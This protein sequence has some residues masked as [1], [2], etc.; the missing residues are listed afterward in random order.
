MNLY[1]PVQCGTHRTPFEP[2]PTL[3]A[4]LILALRCLKARFT[5]VLS[6]GQCDTQRGPFWTFKFGITNR[7]ASGLFMRYVWKGESA[8]AKNWKKNPL[9]KSAIADHRRPFFGQTRSPARQPVQTRLNP[10]WRRDKTWPISP[11]PR[12]WFPSIPSI[13]GESTDGASRQEAISIEFYV[14]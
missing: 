9:K 3:V 6:R 2:V 8:G 1:S 7:S 10:R 14:T 11:T 12:D 13:F 4:P 5:N